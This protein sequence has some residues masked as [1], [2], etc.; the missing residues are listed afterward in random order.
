[1][2]FYFSKILSF[3]IVPGHWFFALFSWALLTKKPSRKKKLLWA[4]FALFYLFSNGV[5]YNEVRQLFEP[6]SK[7]A[8]DIVEPYDIGIVLSGMV[9]F[10]RDTKTAHF[11]E[12]SDRLMQ[13]VKLY[14]SGKIKRILVTGGSGN[15]EF[16]DMKEAD[17]LAEFLL[18]LGIPKEDI[19]IEREARNTRENAV[20]T[21]SILEKESYSTLLLITSSTH[22]PRSMAC[23]KKVGLQCDSYPTNPRYAR[24]SY[25]LSTWLLPNPGVMRSWQALVHEWIGLAAYKLK[26][27]I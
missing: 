2:F 14:S 13:A 3:L 26:G 20:N 27:Y 5:L 22:M 7:V 24:E 4:S 25:A 15:L 6:K 10:N 16:Q 8:A 11:T 17:Y 1:M 21:A 19:L 12:A 9:Y 23:F 18:G